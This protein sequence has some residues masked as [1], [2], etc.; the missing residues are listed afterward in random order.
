M[1]ARFLRRCPLVGSKRMASTKCQ[2][3]QPDLFPYR[4]ITG[5]GILACIFVTTVV[6]A[7]NT[8]PIF[9]TNKSASTA[10]TNMDYVNELEGLYKN[11]T[12]DQKKLLRN[13]LIYI[14]V[15][16]IDTEFNTFRKKARKRNDL[17]QFIFDFLEIGATATIGI[18]NGER[19]KSVIGE[20]LTGFKAARISAN[21]NFRL[22]ET[23]VLFN[24]MVANRAKRLSLIYGKLNNDTDSYPW[25]RAR[26]ELKEYFFA[27][28]VD[29]ALNSLS[30]DTG[31][32]ASEATVNV[33]R[34]K[35]KTLAELE[36][37]ASCD[38]NR[39]DLFR[40]ARANDSAAITKLKD[41]LKAN[42][43]LT[44]RTAA[45]IEAL[46]VGGLETVY[47]EIAVRTLNDPARMNPLC[48]ALK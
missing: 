1:N 35:T 3:G 40:R 31:A 33:E 44:N 42:L 19:A 11:A 29:D 37:A 22:M 2:P 16:Q 15:E 39:A 45:E 38:Q 23:Q 43:A 46:D 7:Q 21:K 4:P 13:R 12:G 5:L 20:A 25:E 8:P 18:I 34:L 24:K 47:R 14:G 17:L 28:T 30:I 10:A 48:E 41:A 32:E 27:G 36:I 26:S 9:K 6:Q